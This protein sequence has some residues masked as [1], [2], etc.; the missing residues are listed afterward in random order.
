MNLID[1]VSEMSNITNPSADSIRG[2]LEEDYHVIVGD[3]NNY[4]YDM[5][6]YDLFIEDGVLYVG[7]LSDSE[8]DRIVISIEMAAVY[9]GKIIDM[10]W[11]SY[12]SGMDVFILDTLGHMHEAEINCGQFSLKTIKAQLKPGQMHY[13]NDIYSNPKVSNHPDTKVYVEDNSDA[14]I[15]GMDAVKTTVETVVNTKI[16]PNKRAADF[17]ILILPNVTKAPHN[18]FFEWLDET[19]KDIPVVADTLQKK[20]MS[21]NKPHEILLYWSSNVVMAGFVDPEQTH[22]KAAKQLDDAILQFHK[23]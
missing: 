17:I 13:F 9:D 18:K 7:R 12:L 4:G 8:S 19:T 16:I 15:C 14:P 2:A 22:F 20:K 11:S 1:A 21:Y 3:K 5:L 6:K 10:L 23:K